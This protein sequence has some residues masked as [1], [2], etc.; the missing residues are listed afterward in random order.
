MS[1]VFFIDR[2][3]RFNEDFC[4]I[5]MHLID[6]YVLL[7]SRSVPID[8]RRSKVQHDVARVKRKIPQCALNLGILTLTQTC[9]VNILS[10]AAMRNWPN[11]GSLFTWSIPAKNTENIYLI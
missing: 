2:L 7:C 10:M 9:F 8:G 11:G 4:S 3:M 1:E 6:K 5:K